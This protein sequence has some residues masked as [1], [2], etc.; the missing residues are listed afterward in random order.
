MAPIPHHPNDAGTW[1][2]L[3]GQPGIALWRR[4]RQAPAPVVMYYVVA[5]PRQSEILYDET[6]ARARFIELAGV[7]S[8][9]PAG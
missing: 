7:S 5:P 4:E 2:R 8:V 9:D 6:R 1:T 3:E